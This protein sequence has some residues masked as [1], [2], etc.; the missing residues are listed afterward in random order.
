MAYWQITL[1]VFFIGAVEQQD[2]TPVAGTWQ[3]CFLRLFLQPKAKGNVPAPRAQ[4]A[5]SARA[6]AKQRLPVHVH[7]DGYHDEAV[8]MSRSSQLNY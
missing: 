2:V 4:T 7:R 1:Y 6:A 3:N 5:R 8:K